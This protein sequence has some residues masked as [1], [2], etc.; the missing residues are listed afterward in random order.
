MV[1]EDGPRQPI[2]AKYRFQAREHDGGLL[3]SAG[4]E[5]QGKAG[6]VV[7]QRQGMD[8]AVAQRLV[9]HEVPLPQRIKSRVLAAEEGSP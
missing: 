1:A 5:Q 9:A 3:A 2:A 6:V 8:L 7:E 4:G